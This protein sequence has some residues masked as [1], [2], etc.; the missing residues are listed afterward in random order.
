[1]NSVLGREEDTSSSRWAAGPHRKV[2]AGGRLAKPFFL[3][4]ASSSL[5]PLGRP[6]SSQSPHPP[7]HPP[8]LGWQGPGRWGEEQLVTTSI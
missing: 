3:A 1:M 8:E 4:L 2:V 5:V 7:T 6:W